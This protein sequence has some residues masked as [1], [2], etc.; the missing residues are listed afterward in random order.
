VAVTLDLD[1][2]QGI[3]ARG[4]S[5]LRH[6]RFTVFAAD[7]SGSG[8]A[9]LAW[10]LPRITTAGR[11]SGDTAVQVA[12]TPSGL[13]RLGLPERAVAGFS[14]EFLSGMNAPNRSRFLGDVEQSGPPSWAWGGPG[15]PPI[16][17]LILLYA[18]SMDLLNERQAELM[19][20]FAEVGARDVA[21]LDTLERLDREPFGFR[22]GIAQPIIEGLP[23][24]TSDERSVAA[25][26]FVL[27]YPDGFGQLTDRPLLPR[28]DDPRHLLPADPAGTGAA[29]LGRNGTYLVLRQLEQDVDGF[30]RYLGEVTRQ[31]DGSDDAG[32]RVALAAKMVGR[33]PSGAPLV[34]A[35]DRDTPAL[36]ADN[37]FAYHDTDPLGLACPLGAHIRRANPRDS[38]DPRP[39][40]DASLNV[41]DLHR[42][43]RRGRSYGPGSGSGP[44][45]GTGLHF[46]CLG[47]NLARQFEFVQHS[48]LNTPTF[49]GLY[50]DT[51]PL[52][53]SR[54]GGGGTFTAPTRPVR[55]RYRDLPQFVRTR[56]GA[57]FFLPGVCALRYLEQLPT[58]VLSAP[59]TR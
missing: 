48:W 35:P 6:A 12:F 49:N 46:I 2:I 4:Y 36:S 26:E 9:L 11:F 1:D 39:G 18:A 56:G 41:D 22:D 14:L 52:V 30:W 53:G 42:L 5:G 20:R 3:L 13:R 51:D 54:Y 55:R 32:A 57:Y 31:P 43:V 19:Q 16:D 47:A 28:S 7:P 24:A 40:S 33:W 23:K 15:G 59:T 44:H 27:G 10:L 58:S 45:A 29:D 17:G 8:H 38:L 25:G 21:V 37:D 34:K 50:D